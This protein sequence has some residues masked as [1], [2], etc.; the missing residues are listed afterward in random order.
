[1][2]YKYFVFWIKIVC[3]IFNKEES[4]VVFS[5]EKEKIEKKIIIIMFVVVFL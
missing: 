2:I 4:L 3:V 5:N 1:M